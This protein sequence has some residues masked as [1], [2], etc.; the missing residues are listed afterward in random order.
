MVS[1]HIHPYFHRGLHPVYV[2]DLIQIG[3]ATF[4]VVNIAET[5]FGLITPQTQIHLIKRMG[6]PHS[7]YD[8]I[9]DVVSCILE[10]Q[11]NVDYVSPTWCAESLAQFAKGLQR[12]VDLLQAP[13]VYEKAISY[14]L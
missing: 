13:P 4:S 6:A 14:T 2:N 11:R 1:D 10:L 9:D 7:T 5:K 3:P 12:A 8:T